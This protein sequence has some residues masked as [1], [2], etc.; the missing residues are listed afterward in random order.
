MRLDRYTGERPKFL[1][2]RRLDAGT[3]VPDGIIFMRGEDGGTY[4]EVSPFDCFVLKKHDRN[5]PAALHAYA[6]SAFAY[7]DFRLSEDTARLALEWTDVEGQK[8]PD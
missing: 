7:G 3:V 5:T 4:Y 2:F 6:R 1:V 8:D